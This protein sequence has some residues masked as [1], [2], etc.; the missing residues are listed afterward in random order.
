[1]LQTI[2]YPVEDDETVTD[3]TMTPVEKYRAKRF[4]LDKN[5]NCLVMVTSHKEQK[6]QVDFGE[7]RQAQMSGRSEQIIQTRVA[8]ERMVIG[9]R[10]VSTVY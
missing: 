6:E 9:W 8:V 2:Y 1:M 3:P 10:T 4:H 5:Y 7:N